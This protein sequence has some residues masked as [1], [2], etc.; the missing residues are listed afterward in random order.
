MCLSV[1]NL[2]E[3]YLLQNRQAL[4]EILL[5]NTRF[6]QKEYF[7]GRKENEILERNEFKEI[8]FLKELQGKVYEQ[9]GTSGSGNHFVEFGIAEFS[10]NNDFKI[11][12]GSYLAVLSHSGSRNFGSSIA[13]HYTAVAKSKCNLPKGAV[14]L[15]WLDLNSEEGIEYWKAMNLAGDYAKANHHII[16]TKISGALG[17]NPIV[18]VEN[19]HNFAWKEKL[20]NGREVIVHRKGATP[21]SK[22]VYG[23]IP[24]SMASPGFIVR[25]KGNPGSLNSASHGAGRVLS[26]SK[27]KEKFTPKLLRETL[28]RAG[29]EL[30]GGG[31]DEA[32]MAYKNIHAVME[33]QKNLVDIVGVFH[34]KIVRMS[35]D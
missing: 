26:R 31:L 28:K 34:P 12:E 5:K 33:Q 22:D 27:A 13:K 19:H 11:P 10:D 20:E 15:A 7:K 35:G 23:I 29:V 18:R 8:K 14:N 3:K 24:G 32:P 6:G 21:A 17:E 30:M 9:L 4:K 25:G 2:D 16:H 1:Y